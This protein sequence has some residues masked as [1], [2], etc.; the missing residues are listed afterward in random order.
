MEDKEAYH[1]DESLSQ[2]SY[3]KGNIDNL[4]MND[5]TDYPLFSTVKLGSEGVPLF[6]S[7]TTGI[8]SVK[9]HFGG[10][11]LDFFQNY[12]DNSTKNDVDWSL[13]GQ[14]NISLD[15]N[16]R[17]FEPQTVIYENGAIILEQ[18]A[19]SIIRGAPPLRIEKHSDGKYSVSLTVIDMI[20]DERRVMGAGSVGV[21]T[22]LWSNTRR[23]FTDNTEYDIEDFNITIS[24]KY[25][26]AWAGWLRNET[27]LK[28][29]DITV[30]NNRVVI[31]LGNNT[32][33]ISVTYSKVNVKLSV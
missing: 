22:E 3:L 17:Y 25:T 30:T 6:A 27:D 26:K 11:Q 13:S 15:V 5:H 18:D 12:P 7:Q 31:D 8:L 4:I 33:D 29:E 1:M 32:S 10:L 19:G 14:G 16:N 28:S 2:F 9:P 23:T 20:G 24:T 21:S